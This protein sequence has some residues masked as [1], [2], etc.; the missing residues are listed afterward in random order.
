MDSNP[1]YGYRRVVIA[2]KMN[3][4]PIQRIM[5][6]NGLKPKLCRRKWQ[7]SGDIGLP[8]A[9]YGNEIKKIKVEKPNI[10]WVGNRQQYV[11]SDGVGKTSSPF[12]V[13][14]YITSRQT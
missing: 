14:L 9:Q 1:A 11:E 13:F 5:R 10:V 7:K 8:L 3:F 6:N 12:F 2:L 4:K